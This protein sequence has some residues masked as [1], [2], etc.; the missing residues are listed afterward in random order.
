MLFGKKLTHTVFLLFIFFYSAVNGSPDHQILAN[1]Q[2]IILLN[3]NNQ[4]EML[5]KVVSIYEDETKELSFADILQPSIQAQFKSADNE[6]LNLGLSKSYYWV[7]MDIRHAESK[8]KDW[9]LEIAYP[10]MD[11]IEFYFQDKGVWKRKIYGDYLPFD[12]REIDHRHFLI[13]LNIRD[14]AVHT[15]I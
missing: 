9:L 7:R 5:G 15:F 10:I 1:G 3:D 12:N 2:K 13:H 11:S 6:G 14:E 8:H 4:G